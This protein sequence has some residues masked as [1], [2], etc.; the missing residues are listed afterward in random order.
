MTCRPFRLPAFLAA[1]ALLALPD[2]APA[3]DKFAAEFLKVGIGARALGMGGAFTAIAD[4]AGAGWWNPAGLA[5]LERPNVQLTHAEMFG[6]IVKHDVISGALPIGREGARSSVGF[7][8]I[9]LGVDDI[10]VTNDALEQDAGGL[11]R[12]NPDKVRLESAYDLGILFSYARGLGRDWSF[13][14]NVKMIRQSLVDEGSSF[15][16][17]A[18][19]GLLWFPAPTTTLG[20]RLADIT[21][22]QIKWDTGRQ[23][24]VAPTVTVGGQTTREV[25]LLKG[26]ITGAAD[27]EMAFENLGDAD[28]FSSGRLSGNLH[29]GLEYWYNSAVALRVGSNAGNFAAG[30]GVR[31]RL[32]PLQ[33]FGVDYAFLDH[34]ELDST[35][36]VTL[37]V[38]W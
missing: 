34:D 29:A 25:E 5:L 33:R 26:S 15:G 35:N 7:T 23:E 10:Q 14:G 27:V 31:F 17:G 32:G 18:D 16:I 19:L 13:G 30:A 37:N 22:T 12:L 24:T 3:A 28:Q 38:G 8:V 4:D 2:S 20:L 21:T 9:R 36:R 11:V 1:V 6:S